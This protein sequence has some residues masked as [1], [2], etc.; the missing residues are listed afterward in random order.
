MD[1]VTKQEI[2]KHQK[3]ITDFLCANQIA[4]DMVYRVRFEE[5]AATLASGEIVTSVAR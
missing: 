1:P 4:S 3:I 5:M 2:I